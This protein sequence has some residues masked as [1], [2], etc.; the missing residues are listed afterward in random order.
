MSNNALRQHNATVGFRAVRLSDIP[1][2]PSRACVHCGGKPD[3]LELTRRSAS[4]GEWRWACMKCDPEAGVQYWV[5]E[6][7]LKRDTYGNAKLL[8]HLLE[9]R[10]F[11]GKCLE[12]F[13][14]R[15]YERRK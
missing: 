11:R 6:E 14:E 2:S 9:K 13:L 8:A 12:S 7:E 4:L 5:D 3:L 10:W 15:M 1:S